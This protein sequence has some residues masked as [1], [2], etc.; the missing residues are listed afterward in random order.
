MKN[1]DSANVVITGAAGFLGGRA[2]K[3]FAE[4]SVNKTI[5]ATARKTKRKDELEAHGC[6]FIEGDLLSPAFCHE[7]TKDTD[8]VV[9][10]AALSS[11]FGN[12]SAFYDSNFLATKYLLDAS[13]KNGVKKFIF[14]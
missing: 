7:L 11:P 4:N 14:I 12:Y 1:I 6:Q 8:I 13:I 10:C 9:H 5:I 3:Y 2:A